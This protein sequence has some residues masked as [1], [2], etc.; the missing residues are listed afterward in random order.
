MTVSALVLAGSRGL[1]DPLVQAAGVETKAHIQINGRSMLGRVFDALGAS[2]VDGEIAL[3]GTDPDHERARAESWPRTLRAPAAGSPAQSVLAAFETTLQPPVLITTCDHPLLTPDMIDLFVAQSLRS[4][5]DFTAGLAE[6][7][8]IEAAYPDVARTYLKIGGRELS[9]CNLFFVGSL[10]GLEAVRFWQGAERDRKRPWRI[11]WRFG[12]LA[13]LRILAGG[14]SMEAVFELASRRV[15]ARVAPVI[16]PFAE[17][18]IDVDKP[19]DLELVTQII[20]R[21]ET[22]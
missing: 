8:T 2:G 17:A 5:A 1:S 7:G 14:V 21:R 9:G 16:L 18:A 19:S 12:P 4:G 11:A 3:S 20:A 22:A 13:A 15:G 6:R 10:E